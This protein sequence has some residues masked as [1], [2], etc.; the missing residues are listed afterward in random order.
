MNRHL[1]KAN[2]AETVDRLVSGGW[3]KLKEIEFQDAV[4]FPYF[5]SERRAGG[6]F[7]ETPIYLRVPKEKD[8]R[9][10]RVGAR[11]DA[12]RYGL[13]LGTDRDL[14]EDLE[15]LHLLA[16]CMR[17]V[18]PPHEPFEP[19]V[20]KLEDRFSRQSLWAVWERLD[21]LVNDVDPRI[22]DLDEAEILVVASAVAKDRSISPLA[23]LDHSSRDICIITM[24]DRYVA[25][26]T[27]KSLQERS[28]RSTQE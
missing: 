4:Y 3:E 11:E 27:Q 21:M 2:S 24:A 18:T 9:K 25:S 1:K 17:S 15:V 5:I 14:V 7:D 12:G 13:D 16:L 22:E 6:G 20:E 19:F 10:A 23:V 28:G 26:E 8:L